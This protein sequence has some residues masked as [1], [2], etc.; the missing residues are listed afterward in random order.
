MRIYACRQLLQAVG[1]CDVII[2]SGHQPLYLI[3]LVIHTAEEQDWGA[4]KGTDSFTELI[5]VH[6][7]KQHIQQDTVISLPAQPFKRIGCTDRRIH[8]IPPCFQVSAV[9]PQYIRF[10]IDCQQPVG[11]LHIFSSNEKMM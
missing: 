11:M 7:R 8:L 1:F 3:R 5:S 9:G 6:I 4:G 10:I 2:P